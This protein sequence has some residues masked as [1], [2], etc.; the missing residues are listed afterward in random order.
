MAL[1]QKGSEFSFLE[2]LLETGEN[3]LDG[4][5]V[6]VKGGYPTE[7]IKKELEKVYQQMSLEEMEPEEIRHAFQLA[8]IKGMR[9]DFLQPNHQMT[10]DSIASF[11]AYLIEIIV[12]PGNHMSIA[13]LSIGTGNLVW[14]I[15]HFLNHKD[16]QIQLSG[17]DNDD[18]LISLAAMLS[19]IQDIDINL[20]HNDA[21]QNLL[22]E[23]VDIM[24]SDLPIG[25]YPVDSQAEKFET[26]NSE[27]HSF[28]HHLLIEQSFTYLNDGGFGFYIVPF[29]LFETEEGKVLLQF[30]QKYG[31]LQGLIHLNKTMFKNEQSRKSILIL[32]KKAEHAKQADE[33]LLAN[34][35]EFSEA[36]EM[37]AFLAEINAWQE[38]QFEA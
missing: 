27:G 10:P 28:S 6:F 20:I 18:L 11:I 36:E 16:R 3:I 32:Q 9:E 13:D 33:V 1:L 26:A 30:I 17:V 25:Y 2:S 5:K 38:E 31:H 34:A 22:L 14:T 37:K 7:E 35:P 19:A 4:G 24:V 15:Y 23:P 12:Q 21:L 8:L 29:N